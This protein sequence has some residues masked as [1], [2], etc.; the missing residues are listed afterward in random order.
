[1]RRR[2]DE[3]RREDDRRHNSR[4]QH[5]VSRRS[6]SIGTYYSILFAF[7]VKKLLY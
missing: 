6:R 7:P 1:M 4:D 3:R 2:E 5:S